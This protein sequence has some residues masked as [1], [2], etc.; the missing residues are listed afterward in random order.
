MGLS[1]VPCAEGALLA[2]GA[3]EDE[4]LLAAL[5]LAPDPDLALASL[6]RLAEHEPAIMGE[7]SS[8]PGYRDR[9]LAVLGASSALA[10]HLA[11]HLADREVLRS[12]RQPAVGAPGR[13]DP[14]AIRAE[15]LRAVT[16]DPD[17]ATPAARPGARE[18]RVNPQVRYHGEIPTAARM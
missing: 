18:P 5:G 2:L 9:L 17:H 10:D 11:R 14:A 3:R 13:P 15:L 7:L 4:G 12:A 6:A 8:D 1:D 16:A